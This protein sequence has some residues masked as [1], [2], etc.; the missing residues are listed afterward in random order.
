VKHFQDRHD[1]CSAIP[2]RRTSLDHHED[3]IM[4]TT[5]ECTTTVGVFN[6]REAAERG[7]AALK[8][9]G[10]QDHEIGLISKDDKNSNAAANAGEGAAYGAVVGAAGGAAIGAGI[11]A[12]VIPVIGPVLAIGTLGTILLNAAGGAAVAS[13]AGALIGW[14]LS[15]DDARYYEEQVKDGKYLVTVECGTGN[16]AR[17]ILRSGGAYDRRTAPA[18]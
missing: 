17:D 14:G 8:Q 9:A 18:V 4:A 16:T 3:L 15:E 7:I 5:A 12:G 1:P 10:Y 2:A 11:L 6:T 13:I